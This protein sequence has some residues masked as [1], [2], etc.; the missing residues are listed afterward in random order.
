MQVLVDDQLFLLMALG[1]LDLPEVVEI[2][3]LTVY[4]FQLRIAS[5]IAVERTTEGVLQ[6]IL[7]SYLPAGRD[8]SE[9]LAP[10][11]GTVRVANP[12]LYVVDAALIRADLRCNTLAAEVIAVAQQENCDVRLTPG[13][14]R[15]SLWDAL[16]A[17]D[18][19]RA[20]W[21]VVPGEKQLSVAES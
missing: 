8:P 6:R 1:V 5:A 16:T 4:S 9:L 10:D 21:S 2:P 17:A 7:S 3:V 14:A 19:P 20:V 12:T 18:V 15:G 13:N 11:S